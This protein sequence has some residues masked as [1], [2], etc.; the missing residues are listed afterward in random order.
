MLRILKRR[1][2]KNM[3]VTPIAAMAFLPIAIGDQVS[4]EIDP[5]VHQF[6]QE[7][8]IECHGEEKQKGDR[9]FDQLSS[10]FSNH[11]NLVLFEDI[12]DLLNLGEMP[13][14]EDGVKQPGLDETRQ[15]VDSL[16]EMLESLEESG[17]KGSAVLR[18]LNRIEY[19]NT[20]MDLLGV[21]TLN[22][23]PTTDFPPDDR[24]HGF[25]NLGEAQMTSDSL[26]QHYLR[27]ADAFLDLAIDFGPAPEPER[28]FIEPSEFETVTRRARSQNR[29]RLLKDDRVEIGHGYP[30]Q[31]IS[32]P[33]KFAERGV[34]SDGYYRIRVKANGIN[35][36]SHPYTEEDLGMSMEQKMQ[37]ALGIAKDREA[38]LSSARDGRRIATIFELADNRPEFYEAKVWMNKGSVPFFNWINGIGNPRWIIRA[39]GYKYHGDDEEIIYNFEE[40]ERLHLEPQERK[41]KPVGRVISDVYEGPRIGI[42]SVEIEGPIIDE[43]PTA[44]HTRIFGDATSPEEVDIPEVM[45][46]FAE[47]AFRRPVTPAEAQHYVDFVESRIEGGDSRLQAI[48]LG[49]KGVL[50]SPRFLYFDE[51]EEGQLDDYQLATRLSYFLWSSMP[52]DELLAAASDGQLQ[53]P[54]KRRQQALRMLQDERSNGFVSG[55]TEAWLR[56]DKLGGMPPDPESF[57]SYYK[58]RLEEDMLAETY[59]YFRHFLDENLP[60]KRMLD[61]DFTFVNADLANHYGL[62]GVEGPEMRKVSLPAKSRRGG[63]LGHASILTLTANGVE[64]S[65]VVRGIWVLENILGTPPSP[66]PPDVEPLEPDLRG[67]TTIRD[68]LRKHREVETCR[69]CHQ[70]IDPLGFPL[71]Y[72]DPVGAFREGYF[73][74]ENKPLLEIDGHG[75]MASGEV[76]QD[77][78]DLKKLLVDRESQFARTIV[79]KL[80]TYAAGRPMTY[81]DEEAIQEILADSNN[82]DYRLKQIVLGVVSSKAF[83]NK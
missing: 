71:E 70:K 6:V 76:F 20:M 28:V 32:H 60:V 61:S 54:E 10:D 62:R 1:L 50:M 67:A 35:R 15:V 41:H 4:V 55:F 68:Q 77:E 9:R 81:R 57:E 3:V 69:D 13:P 45:R 40:A 64:T 2:S 38:L 30:D 51:G 16:T 72:F 82:V 17:K 11:D 79:D 7:Y 42:Y 52:D 46:R 59:A 33:S 19:R 18:R 22:I 44:G 47:R 58:D 31:Y 66:P 5:V 53:D 12:L 36:L 24:E 48:K 63:L 78:R 25:V 75:E 37:L 43:W 26:M 56:L 14:D 73:V 80:L 27:A 8:C 65:P 74:G 34:S 21:E 39:I 29:W 49:L 83:A 23:D